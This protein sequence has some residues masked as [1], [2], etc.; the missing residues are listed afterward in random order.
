MNSGDRLLYAI[1]ARQEMGWPSF[2]RTFGRVCV[3]SFAGEGSL[4]MS[5]AR[6][7]TARALDAL[8]HVEFDFSSTPRVYAARPALSLLPRSG[9]PI[10][11]LSGARAPQ[12]VELLSKQVG[13]IG[14]NLSLGIGP[15][16]HKSRC[17]PS[18]I[19]LAGERVEDLSELAREAQIAFQATPASWNILHFAGSLREYLAQCEW[20]RRE[21]LNWEARHFDTELLQ[22]AVGQSGD[23][24]RLIKYVHPSR[25]Y[26]VHYLWRGGEAALVDPDWGRFAALKETGRNILHYDHSSGSVVLPATIPLPKLLARG[27]CL[28]SGLAPALV[29]SAMVNSPVIAALFKVY[30]KVPYELAQIVAAKLDQALVTDFTLLES[31]ND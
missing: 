14:R 31:D 22:F 23:G 24:P 25:Q 16:Q 1:S 10:A 2:K 26:P 19:T 12:T 3:H 9:L 29:G 11:I 28:C 18:R 30:P 27:L 13:I 21:P 6:Y 5:L 17:I 7:E 20:L 15:Q 4:D 8:G